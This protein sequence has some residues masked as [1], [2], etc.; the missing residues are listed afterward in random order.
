MPIDQVAK[1]Y[2]EEKLLDLWVWLLFVFI[3][4]NSLTNF[5]SWKQ[6]NSW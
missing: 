5:F 6:N 1:N 4:F 2:L 3:R